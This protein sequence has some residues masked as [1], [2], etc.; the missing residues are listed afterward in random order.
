MGRVMTDSNPQFLA[1]NEA[2]SKDE[3]GS[4]KDLNFTPSSR[5]TSPT[6]RLPMNKPTAA[7]LIGCLIVLI[8]YVAVTS[9][10]LVRD[11][12]ATNSSESVPTE[13]VPQTPPLRTAKDVGTAEKKLDIADL[14][15]KALHHHR[16]HVNHKA[17]KSKL[18][19]PITLL[20]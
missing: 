19:E 10:T 15:A 4:K 13:A 14:Q 11:I 7:A 12:D 3:V 8:V 5:I 18:K 9:A 17:L 1:K 20:L 16:D 6:G 2:C